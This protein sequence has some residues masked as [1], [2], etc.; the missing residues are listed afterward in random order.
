MAKYLL[1]Y[2]EQDVK[3]GKLDVSPDGVLK[4]ARKSGSSEIDYYPVYLSADENQSISADKTFAQI[5]DAV[6]RGCFIRAIA[7]EFYDDGSFGATFLDIKSAN[8][9]SGIRF[10]ATSLRGEFYYFTD[11]YIR[12]DDHIEF[13]TGQLKMSLSPNRKEAGLWRSGR[14]QGLPGR[15]GFWPGR[16]SRRR[17]RRTG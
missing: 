1:S 15:T 16:R 2:D 3:E 8:T 12:N 13:R 5:M 14:V 7:Q 10:S 6:K 11:A 17:R 9:L 4:S